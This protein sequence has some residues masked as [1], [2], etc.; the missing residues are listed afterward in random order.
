MELALAGGALTED[1]IGISQHRVLISSALQHY[2]S[3]DLISSE[4]VNI[5]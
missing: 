1:L 5:N 2:I 3:V 4:L